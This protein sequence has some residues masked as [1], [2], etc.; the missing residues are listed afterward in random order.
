MPGIVLK[1]VNRVFPLILTTVLEGDNPIF[2]DEKT[3]RQRLQFTWE[4]K[5]LTSGR[6]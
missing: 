2:A 6:V 4:V 1:A 5:W 3:L